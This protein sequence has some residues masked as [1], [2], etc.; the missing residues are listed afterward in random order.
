[1]T[2]V[3]EERSSAIWVGSMANIVSGGCNGVNWP[4]SVL[5][6]SLRVMAGGNLDKM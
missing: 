4:R 5:E 6:V 3:E 1:M 2:F